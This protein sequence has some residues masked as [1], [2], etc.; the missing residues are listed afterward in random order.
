MVSIIHLSVLTSINNQYRGG[1]KPVECQLSMRVLF[2]F[3]ASIWILYTA[4][5]QF[6]LSAGSIQYPNTGYEPTRKSR[7]QLAF[8]WFTNAAVLII[9]TGKFP[10]YYFQNFLL[11]YFQHIHSKCIFINNFVIIFR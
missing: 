6:W 8:Y 9:I 7:Q 4:C 10:T 11:I 2:R 1:S 3:I 5:A